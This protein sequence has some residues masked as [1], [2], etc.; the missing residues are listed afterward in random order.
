MENMNGI[1]I[2]DVSDPELLSNGPSEIFPLLKNELK[3]RE[4]LIKKIELRYYDIQKNGKSI[5]LITTFVDTDKG[6]VEMTFDKDS[7]YESLDSAGKM[8]LEQLGL[9]SLILR[10]IFSLESELSKN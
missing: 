7:R 6:S 10:C 4:Y 5:S 8:L 1:K 9:S 2:I 3:F